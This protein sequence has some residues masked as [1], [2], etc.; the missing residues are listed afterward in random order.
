MAQSLDTA[1]SAADKLVALVAQ[2]CP[3]ALA[4]HTST[5]VH[6]SHH[7]NNRNVT[8]S[9]AA[10]RALA[11][12]VHWGPF[13]C[14]S[15]AMFFSL[16]LVA[17]PAQPGAA[18]FRSNIRRVLDLLRQA[19]LKGVQVAEKAVDILEAMRP[20]HESADYDGHDGSEH[21]KGGGVKDP[22]ERER[23]ISLVRGLAFPY[24]DAFATRPHGHRGGHGNDS[25]R[26]ASSYTSSGHYSPGGGQMGLG[27]FGSGINQQQHVLQQQNPLQST[28]QMLAPALGRT[29]MTPAPPPYSPPDKRYTNSS[30]ATG[31][32][33]YQLTNTNSNPDIY[34]VPPVSSTGSVSSGLVGSGL[35]GAPGSAGSNGGTAPSGNGLEDP[36]M[37]GASVGFGQG[38]WARFLDVMQRGG[39]ASGLMGA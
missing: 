5:H 37:W 14:F 28:S 34:G 29:G 24:H 26:S 33:G 13:H 27:A 1:A 21:G 22:K 10:A 19:S 35:S 39:D 7:Y 6:S 12:H 32:T 36:A 3:E 23:V 31:N 17:D 4:A 8:T 30:S 16:Q 15:A 25:P 9:S 38:E 18:L 2:A 20:L 11:A